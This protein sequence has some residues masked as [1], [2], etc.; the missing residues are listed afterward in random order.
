MI[1]LHSKYGEAKMPLW[2]TCHMSKYFNFCRIPFL[3]QTSVPPV[4]CLTFTEDTLLRHAQFLVEQVKFSFVCLFHQSTTFLLFHSFIV[5]KI[6]FQHRQC[7]I[8]L[9]LVWVL[10]NFDPAGHRASSNAVFSMQTRTQGI[11]N[12]ILAWS[13]EF[14]SELSGVILLPNY[15]MT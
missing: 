7:R 14:F 2:K 1:S 9:W 3:L 12:L 6:D 11:V 5:I 13:S 4:N 8:T 10:L 15:R